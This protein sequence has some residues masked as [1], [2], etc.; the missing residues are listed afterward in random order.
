MICVIDD[1]HGF[2][3]D[4]NHY[5]STSCWGVKWNLK[6]HTHTIKLE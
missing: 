3:N 5:F 4:L 2:S 6:T 1:K